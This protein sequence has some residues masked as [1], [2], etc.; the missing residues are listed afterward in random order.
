M[1]GDKSKRKF[2]LVL[3]IPPSHYAMKKCK[4]RY[5]KLHLFRNPALLEVWLLTPP[6][7]GLVRFCSVARSRSTAVRVIIVCARQTRCLVSKITRRWFQFCISEKP[8]VG[9]FSS[10][11]GG[12]VVTSLSYEQATDCRIVQNLPLRLALCVA[13]TSEAD[14]DVP[15]YLKVE[16]SVCSFKHSTVE[17]WGLVVQ[18][19]VLVIVGIEGV[20]FTLRPFCSRER[21]TSICWLR[22]WMSCRADLHVTAKRKVPLSSGNLS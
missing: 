15:G 4:G 13:G 8:D 19:H 12:G 9:T 22:D 3:S 5:V 2:A 18:R 14:C 11:E 21:A 6:T 20:S 10:Y 17:T 7:A 1:A 16:F